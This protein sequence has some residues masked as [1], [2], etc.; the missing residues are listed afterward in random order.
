M[1][2]I[3]ANPFKQEKKLEGIAGWLI[4][5]VAGLILG[6][7]ANIS[8][9]INMLDF[10]LS[11]PAALNTGILKGELYARVVFSVM[12]IIM[13]AYLLFLLFKKKK[14]FIIAWLFLLIVSFGFEFVDEIIIFINMVDGVDLGFPFDDLLIAALTLIVGGS[15]T[16]RSKRVKNTFIN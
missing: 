9:I 2:Q 7:P 14:S 11:P 8:S 10:L 1:E 15:Y 3:S 13:N 12:L 16:L 4:I 5:I 6:I